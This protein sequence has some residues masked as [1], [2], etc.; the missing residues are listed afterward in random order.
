MG[1]MDSWDVILLMVAGY[2][3]VMALV[4]LMIRRRDQMQAEFRE[5]VRKEKK[6]RAAEQRQKQA[7]QKRV[8]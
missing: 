4:R 3:A 6:R 8:A 5:E 2:V 1:N 7:E